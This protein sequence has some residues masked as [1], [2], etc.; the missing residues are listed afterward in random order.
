MNDLQQLA[1]IRDENLRGQASG[2]GARTL[3]TSIT[4]EALEIVTSDATVVPP[5]RGGL[6][7]SRTRRLAA[8]GVAVAGLA[9]AAVIGP[10]VVG[11]TATSYA[12]SAIDIELRGD[13]YVATIK[14]PLA[15]YAEYTKGFKAVGLD[16]RLQLVPSSPSQVGKV[17][18]WRTHGH[19]KVSHPNQ[20][21]FGSG[22]APAGCTLGQDGCAMTVIVE[23]DFTGGAVVKLGRPARPGEK[24]QNRGSAT[25][26]GEMLEGYDPAEKTVGEVRAEARDRGLKT[27]FQVITPSPDYTG[28]RIE[29]ERR[30]AKVGDDW[31]VWRA[32]S[33]QAGVLRLLVTRERL[34]RNPTAPA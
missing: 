20:L 13:Q 24:Y 15:E 19:P 33:E 34:P 8:G 11:G 14:D 25:A 21:P 2:A 29:P 31:I 27:A 30:R 32:E 28:Y 5:T 12:S 23:S 26:E 4:G 22:S 6:F 3:L 17:T 10:A 7:R 9:A 18:G 16:V 1:R